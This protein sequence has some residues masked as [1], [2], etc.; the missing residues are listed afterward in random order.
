MKTLSNAEAF[1]PNGNE[2]NIPIDFTQHN[3]KFTRNWFRWR[4]QIT[5]STFLKPM[6][7]NFGPVKMIQIGVFEGQDLI[8]CLQNILTHL[9]S[10]VIAIDPWLQTTKLD[11]EVMDTCHKTAMHNLSPWSDKV[12]IVHRMSCNAL[13]FLRSGCYD[14]IVIDGDH[15]ADVVL[16]DAIQSLRLLKPSGV[17][18]FDDV[19]NKIRKKNHVLRGIEL[20]LMRHEKDVKLV[21]QHRFCDA[22]I[23][24]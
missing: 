14:L 7:D 8:W 24:I 23:K 12:E 2:V 19:R 11:S 6:F 3:F 20:F 5:W 15:N 10:K 13:P 9:E 1:A 21:W 16:E 17:M 22:Y 4:N 18:V